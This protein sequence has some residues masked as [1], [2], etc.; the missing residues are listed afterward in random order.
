V[1]EHCASGA[2]KRAYHVT[3]QLVGERELVQPATVY[4]YFTFIL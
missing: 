2:Q 4:I 3:G 1:V